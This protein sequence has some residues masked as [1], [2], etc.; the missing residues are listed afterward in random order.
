MLRTL[1]PYTCSCVLLSPHVYMPVTSSSEGH[2]SVG[3]FY[4]VFDSLSLPR[5]DVCSMQLS[6]VVLGGGG[7]GWR[8]GPLLVI[9]TV[10]IFPRT[11]SMGRTLGAA[12]VDWW[13]RCCTVWG[14]SLP[15]SHTVTGAVHKRS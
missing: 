10:A 11:N 4:C 6:D 13:W 14:Q 2:H 9:L 5:V 12:M 8:G 15:S 7:G 3:V 1:P